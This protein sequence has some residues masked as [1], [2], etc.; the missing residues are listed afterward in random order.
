MER[1]PVKANTVVSVGYD[2]KLKVL[3]VGLVSAW[4]DH[5]TV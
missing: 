3:E 1:M 4:L 2:A 5:Q